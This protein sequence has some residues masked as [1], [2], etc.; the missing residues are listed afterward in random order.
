MPPSISSPMTASGEPM[1]PT[2]PI[3]P[4]PSL[5]PTTSPAR[6]D[7]PTLKTTDAGVK[8]PAQKK[9]RTKRQTAQ[10]ASLN[11]QRM[12]AFFRAHRGEEEYKDMTFQEIQKALGQLWKTAPE[13]P[14][15]SAA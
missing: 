3:S 13:N 14:K 10:K 4:A 7:D 1:S 5:S 11:M 6:V 12:H 9:K 15:N 8:K 2:A